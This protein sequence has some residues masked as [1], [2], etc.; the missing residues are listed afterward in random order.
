MIENVNSEIKETEILYWLQELFLTVREDFNELF[1]MLCNIKADLQ[2]TELEYGNMT[3]NQIEAKGKE[4]GNSSM[5]Q[6]IKKLKSQYD[7]I[8]KKLNDIREM[9]LNDIQFDIKLIETKD[10]VSKYF[11]QIDPIY[12]EM[13]LKLLN[14]PDLSQT[15]LLKQPSTLPGNNNSSEYKTFTG[16]IPI[17]MNGTE[18]D[19][20]YIRIVR[21]KH[22]QGVYYY[23][24]TNDIYTGQWNEGFAEGYGE[25]D[26]VVGGY[27]GKMKH[28]KRNG[29]GYDQLANGDRIDSI[30]GLRK[31]IEKEDDPI[32]N[33][34]F[35]LI[36]S[37]EFVDGL[38]QVFLFIFVYLFI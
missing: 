29:K 17:D 13:L 22:G 16:D 2:N 12:D 34:I 4:D 36:E 25:I 21:R 35:S 7:E 8:L 26:T 6:K 28:G 1:T 14:K 31:N 20:K 37:E 32:N 10:G 24:N 3:V 11:L 27:K 23:V 18:I 38:P 15:H 30:Y 5:K 9:N 19:M 33:P